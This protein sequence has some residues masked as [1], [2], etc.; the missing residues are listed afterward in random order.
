MPASSPSQ[1][2]DRGRPTADRTAAGRRAELLLGEVPR[3]FNGSGLALRL[4][5]VAPAGRAPAR[6]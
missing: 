2:L 6:R 1:I 5:R 4:E 3:P